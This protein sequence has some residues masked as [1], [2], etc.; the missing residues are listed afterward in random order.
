MTLLKVTLSGLLALTLLGGCRAEQAEAEGTGG[1]G[2]RAV[3]ALE[4]D[5]AFIDGV[6][7][8]QQVAMFLADDA[9]ARAH[10]PA[11]RKH[12]AKLKARRAEEIASLK[13]RRASWVGEDETPPVDTEPQATIPAGAGFDRAWAQ[14][15]AR[16]QLDTIAIAERALTEADRAE[17]KAIARALIARERAELQDLRRI[18]P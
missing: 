9:L 11:L 12:A 13:A 16:Q 7:P 6:V 14:A 4:G 10:D 17:T 5:L 1:G 3:A 18:S 8:R 2:G 15:M